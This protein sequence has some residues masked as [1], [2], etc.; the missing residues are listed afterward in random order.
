M[1]LIDDVLLLP[2]SGLMAAFR[3]IHDAAEQERAGEAADIRA[4]L[5][6]LYMML[7]TGEIT[8]DIFD[9]REKDLLDR[10]DEAE[11]NDT[12]APLPG[13]PEQKPSAA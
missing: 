2:A 13:A 3:R 6:R 7:E 11:A 9:V 5:S 12:R 4:E 8:Q 10:F 1:F